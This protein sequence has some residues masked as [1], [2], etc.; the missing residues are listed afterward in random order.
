VDEV[1]WAV[2]LRPGDRL[3]LRT[4]VVSTRVSRS[5]PD[6]GILVTLAELYNDDDG[7]PMSCRATNIVLR[8]PG[9]GD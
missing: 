2:P 9:A 4:T 6:R 8:R 3:R 7:C 5:R 1:R